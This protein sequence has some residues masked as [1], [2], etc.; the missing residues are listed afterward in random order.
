VRKQ[1]A[2]AKLSHCDRR[3]SRN[4]KMSTMAINLKRWAI[5]SSAG[6]M[7][8]TICTTLQEKCPPSLNAKKPAWIST[9]QA[10]FVEA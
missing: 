6:A 7:M 9:K 1:K 8:R 2:R 3:F 10:K 5:T 4:I